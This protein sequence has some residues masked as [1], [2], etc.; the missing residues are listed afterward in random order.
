MTVLILKICGYPPNPV[1]EHNF[2]VVRGE[3][4]ELT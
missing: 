1:M 4:Y 3:F 2:I